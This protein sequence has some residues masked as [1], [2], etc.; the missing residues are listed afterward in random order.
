MVS[1]KGLKPKKNIKK[2]KASPEVYEKRRKKEKISPDKKIEE[3]L[4]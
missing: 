2:K 3:L 1:P 4:A